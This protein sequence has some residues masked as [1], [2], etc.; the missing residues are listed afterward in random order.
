MRVLVIAITIAVASINAGHAGPESSQ[1]AKTSQA[2]PSA[3]QLDQ[4]LAPIALYP[5]RCSRR[6]CSARRTR[7]RRSSTSG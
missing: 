3:A 1:T 4:L 7:Q 5:D 2:A 6:C